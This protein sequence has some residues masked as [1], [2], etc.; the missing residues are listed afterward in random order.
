MLLS[1]AEIVDEKDG[2]TI[3]ER[4]AFLLRL[5]I[6]ADYRHMTNIGFKIAP[7]VSF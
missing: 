6:Y 3:L 1:L 4:V 7:E 2:N 5:S